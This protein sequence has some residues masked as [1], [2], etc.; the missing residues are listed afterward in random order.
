VS[1]STQ[2]SGG[3]GIV[4]LRYPDTFIPASTFTQDATHTYTVSGGFRIYTFLA[5][6]SITF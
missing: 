3:S 4:I 1:T 2:A 6:G 5:S